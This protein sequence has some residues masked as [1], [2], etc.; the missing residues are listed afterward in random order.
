MNYTK[1]IKLSLILLLSFMSLSAFSQIPPRPTPPRLV[2]DMANILSPEQTA[3]LE[4]TLVAFADS[5]SNQITIV[6]VA[7]LQG[8]DAA[9]FAYEIGETWGVGNKKYDNGIVILIKP[10][11]QTKGEVFIAPGYG[12]EGA[13]PDATCKQIIEQEM[14][15]QFRR[16][17]YYQGIVDALHII[18]PLASGEYSYAEYGERSEDMSPFLALGLLIFFIII[19]V[20][21]ASAGREKG[22]DDFNN[23][24]RGGGLDP[25][26]ALI[27]GGMVGRASRGGSFGGFSG[28]GGGFGG[29][30]GGSFGGGGAGGSW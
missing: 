12:L 2:N 16:N 1:I 10:K 13:L 17:D 5:T 8:Y 19:I 30:G 20:I 25:F 15:P 23:K 6:T 28:G 9:Q 3:Y 27:L 21:V 4:N 11:N 14:I 7:D 26:S 29:F 22:G 18:M 24:G